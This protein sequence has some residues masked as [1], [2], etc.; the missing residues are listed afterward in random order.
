[1]CARH[2]TTAQ[3]NASNVP[4]RGR[5]RAGAIPTRRGDRDPMSGD[6]F[7]TVLFLVF[8]VAFVA[9][10][11]MSKRR[12]KTIRATFAAMF[13]TFAVLLPSSYHPAP[14]QPCR[15]GCWRGRRSEDHTSE[16]QSPMYLVCR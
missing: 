5:I 14:R 8:F 7:A 11:G 2:G 15:L 4:A 16:L 6:D 13:L 10:L 1:M 3:R 12:F 9:A